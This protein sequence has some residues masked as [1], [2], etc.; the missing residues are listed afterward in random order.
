MSRIIGIVIIVV[1]A[2]ALL[3]WFG[4]MDITPEGERVIDETQGGVGEVIEDAG[5]A[6]QDAGDDPEIVE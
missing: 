2:I 1:V 6:I 4:F 3:I 5:T